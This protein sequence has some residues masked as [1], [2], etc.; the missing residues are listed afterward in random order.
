MEVIRERERRRRKMIEDAR[1][2][3]LSLD[4]KV[5]VIL[6]GSYARGDFNLWSDVDILL[7]SD[8]FKG[9]PLKRLEN[10]DLPPGFQVI[11]L[12]T[13]ELKKLYDKND[14]LV[15]EALECGIIL[16]DDLQLAHKL[17]FSQQSKVFIESRNNRFSH[18]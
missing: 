14:I 12:N 16:R 11:P 17:P 7:I 6:I 8:T 2:W 4:F 9:S 18:I 1:E 3:A 5:S 10:I 13:N 15:R